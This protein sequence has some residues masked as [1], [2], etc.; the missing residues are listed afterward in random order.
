MRNRGGGSRSG[1]IHSGDTNAVSF[2]WLVTVTASWV[3]TAQPKLSVMF[4]VPL[5]VLFIW[6][7]LKKENS[8]IINF[9]LR[10]FFVVFITQAGVR[11]ALGKNWFVKW[12]MGGLRVFFRDG[13]LFSQTRIA[14]LDDGGS[15]EKSFSGSASGREVRI[16]QRLWAGTRLSGKGWRL[17]TLHLIPAHAAR[18]CRHSLVASVN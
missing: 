13:T 7:L 3:T 8:E 16:R 1:K 18:Q 5:T 10:C 6:H 2:M 9:C 4:L 11:V 12:A 14:A 17:Q 15:C